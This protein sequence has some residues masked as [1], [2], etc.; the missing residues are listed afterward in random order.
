MATNWF[1]A[2]QKICPGIGIHS[3]IYQLWT[4]AKQLKQVWKSIECL[5]KEYYLNFEKKSFRLKSFRLKCKKSNLIKATV[6]SQNLGLELFLTL[7][8]L[9]Q[10][11]KVFLRG[12]VLMCFAFGGNSFDPT[13]HGIKIAKST[14]K[15]NFY[16]VFWWL[17]ESWKQ[18]PQ[19]VQCDVLSLSGWK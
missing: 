14:A 16:D 1:H 19:Q 11:T 7:F 6:F 10:N 2:C 18:M 4:F 9:V 3:S 15:C 13:Y 12:A 5:F 8:Q 17:S